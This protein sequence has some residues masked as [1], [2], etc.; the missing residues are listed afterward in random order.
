VLVSADEVV[1]EREGKKKKL[2]AE[3]V[4]GK[5]AQTQGHNPQERYPP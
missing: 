3:A 4:N 5:K 2:S 1:H